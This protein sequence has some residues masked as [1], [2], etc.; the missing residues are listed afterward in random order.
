MMQL[1]REERLLHIGKMTNVRDLGG[2][3]T[4]EGYYTKSHKYVRSTCPSGISDDLKEQFYQYGIRTVIDL[5]SDYELVHQPHSLK[6]YKDIEYYHINLLQNE[7]MSVLPNDI[8]DYQ[9]LSG[10]YI[11]MIEAN[12]K[13]LKKEKAEL[14]NLISEMKDNTLFGDTSRHTSE[15]YS[16]GELSSYDN[17]PGDIGTEVYMNDMQNSLTDHQQYRL[18]KVNDALNKIDNDEFGYCE[19]CHNKI[20][21]ERLD[22]LPETKLC[23]HCAQETETYSR[24]DNTEHYDSNNINRDPHFYSEYVTDLTDLNKNGSSSNQNGP[25]DKDDL[26]YSN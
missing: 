9:D 10:F 23:A 15:R 22:I 25:R 2:Y 7:N 13:Q 6:G 11:F 5:R 24:Y 16:S 18:D 3:E 19:R 8:K 1:S 12:K 14:E 26:F 4:Q 21:S 20:E 17:H